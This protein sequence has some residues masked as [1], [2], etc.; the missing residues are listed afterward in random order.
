M[1]CESEALLVLERCGFGLNDG[2]E[3]DMS[4]TPVIY[5]ESQVNGLNYNNTST[6]VNG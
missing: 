6:V 3:V 2:K 5:P 1:S 4:Y